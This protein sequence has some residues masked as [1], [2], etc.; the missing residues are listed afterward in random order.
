MQIQ[1]ISFIA[2]NSLSVS[3]ES[4][5]LSGNTTFCRGKDRLPCIIGILSIE[6]H[7]VSLEK[8]NRGLDVALLFRHNLSG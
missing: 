6:K 7:L 8:S 1:N 4:D 2:E 5:H 3:L